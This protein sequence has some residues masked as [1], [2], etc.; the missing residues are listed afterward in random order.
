MARFYRLDRLVVDLL[1]VR[2]RSDRS[3]ARIGVQGTPKFTVIVITATLM[4]AALATPAHANPV[5][6]FS[7]A[8]TLTLG[9]GAWSWFENSRAFVTGGG[10]EVIA[11]AAAGPLPTGWVNVESNYPQTSA[12]NP[13]PRTTVTVDT[14]LTHDDH[15]SGALLKLAN[16]EIL[17]AWSGH[18]QDNKIRVAVRNGPNRKWTRLAGF[19]TTGLMAYNN[20]FQLS[21]GTVLDFA[22]KSPPSAPHVYQSPDNGR[23]WHNDG[24]LARFTGSQVTQ[25]PYVQYAQSGDRI[26][27]ITT[28]G[29]PRELSNV[30]IDSAIYAGYLEGNTIHRSDGSV[31]GVIGGGVRVDALT[32]VY[33]PPIGSSAWSI[34]LTFD[35]AGEPVAAFSIRDR[36]VAWN[37]SLA[38]RYAAGALVGF[39]VDRARCRLWWS[40][41]LLRRG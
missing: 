38:I 7:D 22:R 40:F 25:R 8:P 14:S 33:V 4:V 37:S 18:S 20:L 12:A 26:S 5:V 15:T 24:E 1:V 36:S 21:D 6:S 34:N 11:S 9:Q 3:K 35:A 41:A 17:V 30:G 16:G 10:C 29:H 19:A 31:A 39:I 28:Q 27:F 32:P 23:T 13:T 2:G